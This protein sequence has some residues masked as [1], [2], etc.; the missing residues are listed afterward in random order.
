MRNII[1]EQKANSERWISC[2]SWTRFDLQQLLRE[3]TMPVY[4]YVCKKCQKSFE[5]VLSLSAHDKGNIRCPK[6]G[7]K[8][9]EQEYVAFFAVTSKKS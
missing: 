3:V 4:D 8:K 9:V 2:G 6:C 7:S 1:D 5:L